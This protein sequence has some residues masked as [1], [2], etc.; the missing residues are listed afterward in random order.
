MA[1]DY[2]EKD[3]KAG[4][5]A[6][7]V[8]DMKAEVHNHVHHHHHAAAHHEHHH[9]EK[10]TGAKSMKNISAGEKMYGKPSRQELPA[11]EAQ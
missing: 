6:S 2:K 8:G 5:H 3:G 4:E 1:E 11:N 7:K 10:D 9:G